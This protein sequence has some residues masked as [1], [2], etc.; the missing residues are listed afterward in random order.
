MVHEQQGRTNDT[1]T[2]LQKAIGKQPNQFQRI[3]KASTGRGLLMSSIWENA[4]LK[5][6][7]GMASCFHI[8]LALC[9]FPITALAQ[10][11]SPTRG[12]PAPARPCK[13]SM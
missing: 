11:I 4:G 1:L 10:T 7:I 3:P 2:E 8:V 6:S 13:N 5:K 9:G 12:A